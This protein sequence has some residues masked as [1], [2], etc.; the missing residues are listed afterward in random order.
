M[1]L[2][3][4]LLYA[5]LFCFLVFFYVHEALNSSESHESFFNCA[6]YIA[7]LSMSN[8]RVQTKLYESR[9][10]RFNKH[11]DTCSLVEMA[12]LNALC[13]VIKG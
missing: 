13:C 4:Q 7:D 10:D 1:A 8:W 3:G 5:Q 9:N 6:R 2:K 12:A 11:T